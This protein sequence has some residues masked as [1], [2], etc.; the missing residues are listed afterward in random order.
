VVTGV[1]IPDAMHKIPIV[2]DSVTIRKMVRASDA[3]LERV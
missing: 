1:L 2:D 3:L